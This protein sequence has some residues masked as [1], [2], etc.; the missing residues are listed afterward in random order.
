[1]SWSSQADG[2]GVVVTVNSTGLLQFIVGA[3]I[4]TRSPL[5]APLGILIDIDPVL[6]LFTVTGVPCSSTRL[7]PC[8]LPKF[9]PVIVTWLPTDPVVAD[10]PV[11]T[12]AGAAVVFSDTLSNVPVYS[13]VALM[14]PTVKPT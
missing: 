10:T 13:V 9:C 6:Q 1:M 12:G 7:F 8:E 2:S 3:T 11:I 5:T 4:T 14:L